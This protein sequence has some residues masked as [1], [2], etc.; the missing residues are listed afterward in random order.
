MRLEEGITVMP[1]YVQAEGVEAV[2][3]RVADLASATSVTRSP[4]VVAVAPEVIGSRRPM[5]RPG[6]SVCLTGRSGG[7]ASCG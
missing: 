3:D 2:L 1:E 4:Y 6:G 7:C 5:P